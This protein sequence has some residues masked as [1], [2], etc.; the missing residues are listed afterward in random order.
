MLVTS[1]YFN[2]RKSPC[3]K[4][5]LLDD[6]GRW[7]QIEAIIDTGFSGFLLLPE[8]LV[9]HLKL[10]KVGTT[11]AN[12]ADDSKTTLETALADVAIGADKQ[13]K[14]LVICSG[15]ESS[16]LLGMD[17]LRKF[18]LALVM[19]S[20]EIHLCDDS[21]FQDFAA[22]NKVSIPE[23]GPSLDFDGAP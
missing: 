6:Q 11:K 4:V 3:L 15:G 7:H 22:R 23:P 9:S 10:K 19:T 1:G 8:P 20:T 14:G 17:F 5:R 16:I 18:K 21:K 2:S 12:L 13:T